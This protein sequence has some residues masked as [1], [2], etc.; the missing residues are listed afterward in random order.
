MRSLHDEYVIAAARWLRYRCV[1][2]SYLEGRAIK[3]QHR[4]VVTELATLAREQPDVIGWACNEST[5]LEVKVSCADFLRDKKKL[6]RK[7][8]HHAV[9]NYR[10][11]FAPK[12]LLSPDE[13]PEGW[14]L[15]EADGRRSEVLKLPK[16]Q[17][18]SHSAERDILIS[19]VRRLMSGEACLAK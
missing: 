12:G 10:Y 3:R 19:V 9:G 11:Y 1:L 17:E 18:I 13:M 2:P 6:S 14:G 7:H 15:V 16:F 4:I 8:P 5:L